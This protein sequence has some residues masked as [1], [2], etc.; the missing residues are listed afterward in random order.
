MEPWK[1]LFCRII[2]EALTF[3]SFCTMFIGTTIWT[4]TTVWTAYGFI[5]IYICVIICFELSLKITELSST[6]ISVWRTTNAWPIFNNES[7]S[8]LCTCGA[9]FGFVCLCAFNT[10]RI[11]ISARL[12]CVT[13][14]G[15]I[16]R[17]MAILSGWFNISI[18]SRQIFG[19]SS[20][21]FASG[22]LR[23]IIMTYTILTNIAVG[24]T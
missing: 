18:A 21:T 15:V 17:I 23:A 4:N 24:L 6:T 16:V 14:L 12:A 2:R 5:F 13:E 10:V 8:T 1:C 3:S 7:F 19:R 22:W 11:N 9:L 20:K